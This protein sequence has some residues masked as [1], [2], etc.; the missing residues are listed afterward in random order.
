ML[1]KHEDSRKYL[2]MGTVP[3]P[4]YAGRLFRDIPELE[5][6][7]AYFVENDFRLTFTTATFLD[8]IRAVY[9]NFMS[10]ANLRVQLESNWSKLV[11]ERVDP[12]LQLLESWLKGSIMKTASTDFEMSLTLLLNLCG[13][14]AMQVGSRYEDATQEQR[15]TTY[16]KTKVGIDVIAFSPDNKTAMPVHH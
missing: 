16:G 9:K 7:S 8:L 2:G 1:D 6:I 11:L 14:R 13:Y 5:S 4:G 3:Q 10:K 12:N 15:L